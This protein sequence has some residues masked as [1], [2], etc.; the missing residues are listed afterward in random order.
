MD[1]GRKLATTASPRGGTADASISKGPQAQRAR[2]RSRQRGTGITVLQR[3]D[4]PLYAKPGSTGRAWRA[5]GS[6]VAVVA[7]AWRTPKQRRLALALTAACLSA[8]TFARIAEDYLTN[9]PL[10]RWDVSFARWLSSERSSV[11]TDFFRVLTFIGSPAAVLVISIVVCVLLY[12]RRRIIEAALLPIVL[13]GGELLNLILKLSFHRPRPEVAFVHLDTYSFPSGHAMLSTA[14]YGALAYLTWGR[15]RTT[16]ARFA[17]AAGT[18]VLV[19][20]ICFSRLYLGVHYLSDVLGGAAGG[21]FWLAASIV[22]Q[23]LYGQRFA[24]V[25]ADSPAD[26]LGRRITRS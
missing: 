13:A 9:D 10:A 25:F 24:R 3:M 17:L 23:T 6:A 1:G 2:S 22:L 11:G 8:I 21:A 5:G 15:L 19:A 18:V 4:P 16:R 14:A 26:R 20:L 12:R 7:A